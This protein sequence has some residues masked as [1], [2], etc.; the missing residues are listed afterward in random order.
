MQLKPRIRN[1]KPDAPKPL[2]RSRRKE[3]LRKRATP[4]PPKPQKPFTPEPFIPGAMGA[5]APGKRY[6]EACIEYFKPRAER[7][8]APWSAVLILDIFPTYVC[9]HVYI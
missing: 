9:M 6:Q 1:P 5:V 4:R 3:V 7:A 2:N 8:G